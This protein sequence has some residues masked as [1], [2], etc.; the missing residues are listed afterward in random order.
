M[1]YQKD[2]RYN[3]YFRPEAEAFGYSEGAEAGQ[4]LLDIV[5]SLHD[6]STFS[7]EYL[8]N[9]VDWSTRY[10]FSRAR[11]CLLRPLDI[12]PGDRVLELGCGTGAPAIWAKR[13]PR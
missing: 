5:E 6:R 3:L 7:P 1:S 9:I 8:D 2:T 11:H 12:G 13:G 10:H 4:R